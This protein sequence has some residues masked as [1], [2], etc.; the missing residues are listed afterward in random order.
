MRT[1]ACKTTPLLQLGVLGFRLFQDG[2]VGV[3]V[4]PEGEGILEYAAFAT[5]AA[6]PS[7]PTRKS[8][9]RN[10]WGRVRSQYSIP[11]TTSH[12]PETQ[13]LAR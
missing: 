3:G 4:F 12:A 11:P 9:G 8:V 2:D 1:S 6:P 5:A 7:A 13:C 10:G